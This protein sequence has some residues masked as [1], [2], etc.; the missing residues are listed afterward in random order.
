MATGRLTWQN[1]A[2][3]DFSGAVEAQRA[4]ALAF[5]NAMQRLGGAVET[6]DN[7]RKDRADAAV[8]R[9]ALQYQN[10]DELQAAI[11]SGALMQGVNP[12]HV[13]VG[14]LLKAQAQ[15]GQLMA[16][17]KDRQELATSK[18]AYD[19]NNEYNPLRLEKV[20]LENS[21]LDD[22][23]KHTRGER[24]RVEQERQI[25]DQVGYEMA[26]GY[27]T[28]AFQ[29]P[30][31]IAS[32]IQEAGPINSPLAQARWKA[33]VGA[34]PALAQTFE[35]MGINLPLSNPLTGSPTT[36]RSSPLSLPDGLGDQLASH[37]A[38]LGLPS[39]LLSSV[40]QQ[41]I[42]NRP[43]FL[44]DPSKYHYELNS[45]GK[46]IAKHTGKE[47]TAFG[48]FGILES[49]AKDPGYG[50]K[51]LQNKSLE[52]QAR[53]AAD[54]LAARIKNAGS[55]EAGLAG[56]GEGIKYA[57][58]VL[59]RNSAATAA[60][61]QEAGAMADQANLAVVH[62]ANRSGVPLNQQYVAALQM[63]LNG[64]DDISLRGTLARHKDTFSGINSDQ[65]EK[66]LTE[67]NQKT[68]N[69][70]NYEFAA[71][72]LKN[73][74]TETLGNWRDWVPG[75]RGSGKHFDSSQVKAAVDAF[76]AQGGIG[77]YEGAAAGYRANAALENQALMQTQREDLTKRR[78][79]AIKA[80]NAGVP[81]AAAQ[82][83]QIDAALLQAS[84]AQNAQSRAS[85]DGFIPQK[86]ADEAKK[87][88]EGGKKNNS[89][90]PS[91]SSTAA[92]NFY[93]AEAT[94]ERKAA[95]ALRDEAQAAAKAQK[96][97]ETRNR[98]VDTSRITKQ[99]ELASQLTTER[100][101]AMTR[102]EAQ[103][104]I[105]SQG[106]FPLLSPEQQRLIRNKR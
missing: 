61:R 68:G 98:L 31:A 97:T 82:L 65:L 47:S 28:G 88:A 8:M 38:R 58:A 79:A 29:Q 34:N 102:E 12:D 17:D 101:Q 40:L 99:R 57:N 37:E 100:I 94:A 91:S 46:R 63:G 96:S 1:V 60:S 66:M 4:S 71:Q 92:S 62:G 67:I 6:F 3:P 21:Q 106:L 49:T 32:W 83:Q 23:I 45:E 10:A 59:G 7:N 80:T 25:N 78:E 24:E 42:G 51:P 20:G 103:R 2:A 55:V 54:Y 84:E 19:F 22:N 77:L 16:L 48:P 18:Q 41:E 14:A 9:N 74:P 104:E 90:T 86:L 52:E 85:Y 44:Q 87:A 105:I 39:G 5:D 89:D 64:K 35:E 76:N 30:G 53:F 50:V 95:A 43:E 56:Y 11:A 70:G 33:A 73:L 75:I 15:A 27:R 93:S 69:T 81:G 26:E 36:T 72:F 13:R